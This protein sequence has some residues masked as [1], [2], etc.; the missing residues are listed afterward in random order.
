MTSLE[1]AM[2]VCMCVCGVS[3]VDHQFVYMYMCCLSHT[4]HKSTH[5]RI[6][7]HSYLT[8]KHLINDC[9]DQ[10]INES[11]P[12]WASE[13]RSRGYV[14]AYSPAERRRRIE[15]FLEKRRLRV[16]QK[17]VKYDVRKNFADSR[18]RV[19]GRFVKKEDQLAMIAMG[20]SPKDRTNISSDCDSDP[21]RGTWVAGSGAVGGMSDSSG[22]ERVVDE[23]IG[24]GGGG[25][26]G[27]SWGAG[28]V[29]R[30]GGMKDGGVKSFNSKSRGALSLPLPP[31]LSLSSQP[32]S[33][34]SVSLPAPIPPYSKGR[35]RADSESLQKAETKAQGQGQGQSRSG[36]FL[37][38]T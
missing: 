22:G 28:G 1:I 37:A 10:R 32:L 7:R 33:A 5:P 16:W 29:G 23:L 14:G 38:T 36:I 30:I 27:G 26:V 12:N 8:H 17:N 9:M 34:M 31:S 19:K 21:E 6:F 35:T 15:R 11:D 18:I 25:G 13:G 20:A 2:Y 24:G 3:Y 4:L